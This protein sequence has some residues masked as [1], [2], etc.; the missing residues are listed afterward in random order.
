MT[1]SSM[2]SNPA[3]GPDFPLAGPATEPTVPATPSGGNA[4]PVAGPR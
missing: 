1:T 4:F 2:P 3:A